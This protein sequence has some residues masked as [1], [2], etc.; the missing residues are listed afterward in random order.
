[1]DVNSS[2]LNL[3]LC[4]VHVVKIDF[5]QIESFLCKKQLFSPER[6]VQ[7][8]KKKPRRTIEDLDKISG[9]TDYFL[10]GFLNSQS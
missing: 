3:S 6:A 1:M 2:E 9:G 5:I 4:S 7:S 8:S 10:A